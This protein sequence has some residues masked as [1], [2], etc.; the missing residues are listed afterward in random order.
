MAG[1]ST[2]QNLSDLPKVAQDCSVVLQ[3]LED[4]MPDFNYRTWSTHSL[5]TNEQLARAAGCTDG[6]DA[7]ARMDY[8]AIKRRVLNELEDHQGYFLVA[9][10]AGPS[11]GQNL[12]DLPKVAQD[13]SVV[14]QR[15]EDEMPDFNYRTWSTHSLARN[16]QLA[17]AAGCTDGA[18]AVAPMDDK[19]DLEDHQGDKHRVVVRS[20]AYTVTCKDLESVLDENWFNDV[21]IDFYMWLV[22]ERAKEARDGR[23]IHALTTHFYDVL[24]TW[25]YAAVSHWTDTVDLFSF[26]MLLV[27][28]HKNNHWSL[29]VLNIGNRTFELY[30]SLGRKNWNCYQVLTAY[31][32]KEH[33]DKRKCPLT[34]EAKWQCH[35][36]QNL[37]QQSNSHD[38]GVFVCLYAEC[39]ARGAPFNFSARDIKR[40][41]YR[42]AFEIMSGKLMDH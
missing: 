23:R 2:G 5:A 42:I 21:V 20:A 31:L 14:L 28:I 1:P 38:C 35:Y 39:L 17:R 26:D 32:R 6:E 41:R 11:T 8:E 12:S 9:N 40:L 4:E 29:A 7:A 3:R 15:L 25:G 27:P 33:Q 34:P 37:P 24:R 19:E 30:D 16:E 36:V 18:G 10:M 22:A 13:C